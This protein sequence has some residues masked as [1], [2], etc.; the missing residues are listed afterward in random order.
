MRD[1]FLLDAGRRMKVGKGDSVRLYVRIDVSARGDSRR[2]FFGRVADG[3]HGTAVA[4]VADHQSQ[5]DLVALKHAR[6]ASEISP[7]DPEITISL[8]LILE[9]V[10]Q[11]Q[12]AMD[13][14]E[15]L[16]ASGN[17]SPRL[18]MPSAGC[19]AKRRTSM[20]TQAATGTPSS[21]QLGG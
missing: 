10:R 8:A 12:A 7:D 18:A 15:K 3:G 20:P 11:E 14:V 21:R 1:E 9:A 5:P 17:R 6:R 19:Q 13:L 4:D 16:R 2:F